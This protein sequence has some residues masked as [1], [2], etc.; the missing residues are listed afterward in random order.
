MKNVLCLNGIWRYDEKE[1]GGRGEENKQRRRKKG[2]RKKGEKTG[3]GK[4][5]KEKWEYKDSKVR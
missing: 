2:K 3:M 5:D 4:K 1:K